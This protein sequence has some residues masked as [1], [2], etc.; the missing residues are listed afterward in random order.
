MDYKLTNIKERS[1]SVA[2][3]KGISYEDFCLSIGMSYASFKGSAKK[4][5]LNSD[6][7][8][9]ILTTYPSINAE[10]L[11]TGQGKMVQDL[12]LSEPEEHYSKTLAEGHQLKT[13]P[14]YRLESFESLSE[15]FHNTTRNSNSE[16]LSVPRLHNCDAAIYISGDNMNSVLKAGDIVTYG[17][18]SIAAKHIIWGEMY[19]LSINVGAQEYASVYYVQKSEIDEKHVKLVSHNKHFEPREVLLTDLTAMALVKASIR[20]HY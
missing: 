6:A 13:I 15:V 9:K 10:W 17:Q 5:P 1:L 16:S 4:R 12:A 14:L 7:I 3:I 2:K 19:L 8:E 18:I 20:F 11:L